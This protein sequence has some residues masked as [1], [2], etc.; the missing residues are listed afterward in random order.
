MRH[1]WPCPHCPYAGIFLKLVQGL[2]DH[3]NV[4]LSCIHLFI[5]TRLKQRRNSLLMLKENWKVPRLTPKYA[6][7]RN[8]RSECQNIC[9]KG[10]QLNLAPLMLIVRLYVIV[11]CFNV[12]GFGNPGPWR[13]RRNSCRGSRSSWWSWRYRPPTGRKTSRLPW[14]P[15]SSTTWTH[16]SQ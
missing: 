12:D 14:V 4:C 1:L 9:L 10:A 11:C 6:E 15:P 7:M 8:P 5:K 3:L 2:L 16:V 13:P